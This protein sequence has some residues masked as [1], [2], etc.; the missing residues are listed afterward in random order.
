MK[1]Y[2][3]SVWGWEIPWWG[4]DDDR[5][6]GSRLGKRQD[7]AYAGGQFARVDEGCKLFEALGRDVDEKEQRP[8][9]AASGYLL[10]G[11]GY[12]RH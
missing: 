8:H 2:G 5:V 3:T 7:I 11:R 4:R 6:G 9:V 10:I 12:R 1:R